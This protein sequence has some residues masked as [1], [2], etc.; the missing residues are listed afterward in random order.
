LTTLPIGAGIVMNPNGTVTVPAN[1][2]SGSYT[3]TYTICTVAM[4]T[5]C[6]TATATIVVRGTIDAVNDLPQTIVINVSGPINVGS[7][8][9]NDTLNGNPVTIANAVVT[10]STQGPL[11]IA[12]NGTV[13]VAANTAAGT[14]TITYQICAAGAVPQNCDT[15]TATFIIVTD[16]DGDGVTNIA[17]IRDGTNPNNSCDFR[18]GSISGAQSQ[19]FLN[20]DCDGDGLKNGDEIGPDPR[21]PI[22]SDNDG[23][24]DFLE[25]NNAAP[26]EDNLE[27]FN[28]LTPDGDGNNDVFVIRNIELYPDNTLE[29]YNRW[30]VQVYQTKGYGQGNN[31]FRGISEGRA[32]INQSSE[33][34][35]GTYFYLLRYK[36]T[37]GS[38]KE[39]SGYLYINK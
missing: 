30:G 7:V 19:D 31:Y 8:I 6:D 21:N 25:I 37:A 3:I 1:A 12:A 33:L 26:S 38:N 11:S 35:V 15:A 16:S 36:N 2:P 13:T 34:P 23:I 4:P 10:P 39:R 9:G 5:I 32:T 18:P 24:F 14:Y 29:I 17:E 28:L 27:M 22:D 20:G